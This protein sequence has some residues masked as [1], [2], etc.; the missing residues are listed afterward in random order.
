MTEQTGAFDASSAPTPPAAGHPGSTPSSAAPAPSPGRGDG[1]AAP[2]TVVVTGAGSG[3]G[4][5][6][7]HRFAALGDTVVA[8]GRR[9]GP[10]AGT[11]A[12]SPRIHVRQADVTGEDATAA[13]IEATV[14]RFGRLDVLVNNAA[15]AGGP[16]FGELTRTAAHRMLATSLVAPALLTE[17]AVP[18]LVRTGGTVVNISTTVG[19][20]AWPASSALRGPCHMPARVAWSGTAPRGVAEKPW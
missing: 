1:A 7:A 9:P 6:L 14:E 3:I 20:R 17:A 11:A 5:A 4:R 2:R 10:L 15:L 19:Q 13:V 12:A 18:H 8:V 16:G